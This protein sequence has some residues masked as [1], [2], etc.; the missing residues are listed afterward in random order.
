MFDAEH[1]RLPSSGPDRVSGL[2]LWSVW[3]I[4]AIF[5]TAWM[6]LILAAPWLMEHGHPLVARALYLGFKPLCHQI[7]ARSFH[8]H[9]YPFAVCARCTGIYAG[10][11]V[12]ILLFP[13]LRSLRRLDS[14]SKWLL[15][16]AP[17]PTTIDFALG[18]F[19][20]WAN[21]HWSRFVTAAFFGVIASFYIIPGALDLSVMMLRKLRGQSNGVSAAAGQVSAG[22]T[23][24]LAGIKPALSD[25]SA[26]ERRI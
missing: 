4:C 17:I 13:V 1:E 20:L 14:P 16:A 10:L 6:G 25:Y 26:P 23:G 12:G 5:M 11:A 24:P 2:Q 3:A 9:D 19:G 22:P 18:F 15:I 8:L 21:T 7:D